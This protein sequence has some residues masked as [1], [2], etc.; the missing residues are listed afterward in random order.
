MALVPGRRSARAAAHSESL[1]REVRELRGTIDQCSRDLQVQFTRIAQV[2]AELD[3]LRRG[4]AR[5]APS[6]RVRR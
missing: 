1:A 4:R 2:Q 5:A 3:D 6:Q